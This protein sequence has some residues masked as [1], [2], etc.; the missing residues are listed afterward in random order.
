MS[1]AKRDKRP[2]AGFQFDPDAL[3]KLLKGTF[4]EIEFALLMGSARDG[5][6][7][8]GGDIDLALYTRDRLGL[9]LRMRVAEAVREWLPDAEVDIGQFNG[10][11]PVYRFEALKGRLLFARDMDFFAGAFSL[12]C[13]EYE[14]QMQDYH[15]QFSYRL[16]HQGRAARPSSGMVLFSEN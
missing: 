4:P 8:A 11:E 9:G 12:A 16:E 10:A 1:L 14:S 7:P 13:R 15:R 3:G 6:V 2:H 5:V